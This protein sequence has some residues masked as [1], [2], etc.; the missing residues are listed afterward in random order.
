MLVKP[1]ALD[2]GINPYIG[3]IK[4][5]RG[6]ILSDCRTERFKAKFLR[7]ANELLFEIVKS[8]LKDTY[9]GT[10]TPTELLNEVSAY[11]KC[12]TTKRLGL[13]SISQ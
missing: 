5:E 9:T 6:D 10:T 4:K 13:W 1:A 2:Y 12:I 3:T 7:Y 8:T 11:R